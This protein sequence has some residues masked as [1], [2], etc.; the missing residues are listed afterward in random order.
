MLLVRAGVNADERKLLNFHIRHTLLLR[1]LVLMKANLWVLPPQRWMPDVHPVLQRWIRIARWEVLFW[2]R[3]FH[4]IFWTSRMEKAWQEVFAKPNIRQSLDISWK[5]Y[6]GIVTQSPSTINRPFK[7]VEL[8]LNSDSPSFGTSF[9]QQYV[10]SLSSSEIKSLRREVYI[11]DNVIDQYQDAIAVRKAVSNA[12]KTYI[13]N[14]GERDFH[15]EQDFKKRLD[16]VKKDVDVAVTRCI[17]C[18]EMIKVLY[19]NYVYSF[20]TR[21]ER[22][23]L[24]LIQSND[25]GGRK[26]E[27]QPATTVDDPNRQAQKEANSSIAVSTDETPTPLA[28]CADKDMASPNKKKSVENHNL[29]NGSTP[30]DPATVNSPPRHDDPPASS[31]SSETAEAS[32]PIDKQKPRSVENQNR[33]D[34]VLPLNN[35]KHDASLNS[36]SKTISSTQ[37]KPHNPAESQTPESASLQKGDVPVTDTKDPNASSLTPPTE[38]PEKLDKK[39]NGGQVKKED[40]KNKE[41]RGVEDS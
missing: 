11:C 18:H 33:G 24:Q 10:D 40:A 23:V 25:S 32:P 30:N 15:W 1:K 20:S 28:Q 34:A 41:D 2:E 13:A 6:F 37:Q 36:Q 9:F 8:F 22:Q 12:A 17:K 29:Q 7:S 19:E 39:E 3:R 14:G 16:K 26:D 4:M 27:T 21:E 35:N 38:A 5:G 31:S